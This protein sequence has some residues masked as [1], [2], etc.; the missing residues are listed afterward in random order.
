MASFMRRTASPASLTC[1]S[2]AAT[3][4]IFGLRVS[5]TQISLQFVGRLRTQNAPTMVKLYVHYE[6][7]E[8]EFTLPVRFRVPTAP[9]AGTQPP[10]RRVCRSGTASASLTRA[11]MHVRATRYVRRWRLRPRTCARWPTSRRCL[12]TPTTRDMAWCG[13]RLAARPALLAPCRGAVAL[14]ARLPLF[15]LAAAHAP[16]LRLML[17]R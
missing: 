3:S 11:R 17:G 12:L 6:L 8:P 16:S 14:C 2:S 9:R 15:A 5:H 13:C 4:A 7:E 10:S 1:A